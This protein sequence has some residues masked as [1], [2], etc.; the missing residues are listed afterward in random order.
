MADP[1]TLACADKLAFDSRQAAEAAA[2]AADWQH[3]IS[4]HAYKCRHCQ[5]W[6]LS[7]SKPE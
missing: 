2:L 4:L 3:G 7:S 6:H 1:E 5:L